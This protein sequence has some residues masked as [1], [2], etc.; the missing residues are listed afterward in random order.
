MKR[1]NRID[2][3]VPGDQLPPDVHQRIEQFD[4]RR[5]SYRVYQKDDPVRSRTY[6]M[7]I[8]ETDPD[9][10]FRVRAYSDNHCLKVYQANNPLLAEHHFPVDL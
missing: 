6:T 3:F 1:F 10:L 8:F 4:E 7:L 5:Q 9:S 2:D